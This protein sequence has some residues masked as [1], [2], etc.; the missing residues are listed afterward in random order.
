MSHEEIRDLI[1]KAQRS[2]RSARN[3]LD[4]GDCDFAIARAYYAMFYAA[5]AAL[6][7]RDIRRAKHSGVI[8]AFGKHLVK[9]GHFSPAQHKALQGAFRDRT[10]GDYGGLFPAP[11]D[12]ERRLTEAT[13]F[14][15]AVANFLQAEGFDL[16]PGSP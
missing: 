8:A 13:E 11:E 14:V 2:L 3:L 4:D 15:A 16:A 6:L 12:V 10:E 1:K 9:P 5:T 7:A